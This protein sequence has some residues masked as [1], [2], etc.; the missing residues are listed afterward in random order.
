MGYFE[1]IYGLNKK[2][3]EDSYNRI[4]PT[5]AQKFGAEVAKGIERN[6]GTSPE[7]EMNPQI[8]AYELTNNV[9]PTLRNQNTPENY[10][11]SLECM[12][13]KSLTEKKFININFTYLET[14]KKS[15]QLKEK[16]EIY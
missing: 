13:V 5:V 10:C 11:S 16:A 9:M 15:I 4:L 6:L 3:F 2:A 8:V 12:I 1:K 14:N 7:A